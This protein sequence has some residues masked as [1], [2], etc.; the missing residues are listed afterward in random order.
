MARDAKESYRVEPFS[1]TYV[2]YE[3]GPLRTTRSI[4]EDGRSGDVG[5][6]GGIDVLLSDADDQTPVVG[7]IKADTDVN[8]FFA[9]IQ[10]LMCAVELSTPAQQE[11]LS[12]MYPGQFAFVSGK[13]SVDIALIFLRY[14]DGDQ[15]LEFL[16]LT[17]TLAS[18]LMEEGNS[19]SSIVRR[20]IAVN[21]PMDGDALQSSVVFAFGQGMRDGQL[22]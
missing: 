11:R 21:D 14:G 8:C 13:P 10:S 12:L 17:K 6:A 20:I 22:T 4:C 18:L 5:G 19:A 15:S 7:E 2:D 3:V 16:R 1:F 9:L